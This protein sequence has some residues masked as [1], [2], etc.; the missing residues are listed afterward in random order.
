MFGA[1][2]RQLSQ[3]AVSISALCRE[4]GVNRTQ[5]NRYLAGESFPRPDVLHRICS[6]FGVDARIL[7]EPVD[8][9]TQKPAAA[10]LNPAV[11][12]YFDGAL[13]PV[14]EEI[15][16]S[17]FYRF[18]RRSFSD[19]RRFVQGVTYTFRTDGGTVVRGFEAK[20]AMAAQGLP[21]TATM[22][23]FRGAVLPQE[24]GLG[25]LISRRGTVSNTFT[26]LTRVPTFENNYW[27]GYVA[28]S[29]RE[30]IAGR[31][32][33][34]MVYE[35]LGRD[36]LRVLPVARASGLVS[37]EDLLPYHRTLL[38]IGEPFS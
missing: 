21:A 29:V 36:L 18:S 28:R 1:N 13:R 15:L 14:S 25:I 22:R 35:Y 23:E 38:K 34:R 30:G 26:Y 5:Y 2:L 10:A 6:Y 33:E 8:E 19:E 4:L 3:T 27:T 7:L 20:A 9:I 24:D 17:G 11:A 12:D 32:V 16:P 37:E 31:R